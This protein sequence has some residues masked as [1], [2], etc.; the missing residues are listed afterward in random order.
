MQVSELTLE[1]DQRVIGAGNVARAAGAR[2][3]ACGHI[4]HRADHLWVLRHAEVVVGAPDDDFA[5]PLRGVP[6]RMRETTGDTLEV[7]KNAVAA[8][9]PEGI[10]CRRKKR[11]V[12]HDDFFPPPARGALFR[13]VP[14]ALSRR[15]FAE[16]GT[17][18]L[19][20][21]KAPA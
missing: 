4:D 15:D 10:Q 7:G 20:D 1:L 17:G 11:V 8:L 21:I 13:G 9:I 18:S 14:R 16:S 19:L 12:I 2:P 3:H 6:E 5:G